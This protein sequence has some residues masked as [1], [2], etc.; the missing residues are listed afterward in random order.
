MAFKMKGSSLYGSP[1]KKDYGALSQE[2]RDRMKRHNDRGADGQEAPRIAS[3]KVTKVEPSKKS[4]K[5][6]K[7]DETFKPTKKATKKAKRKAVAAKIFGSGSKRKA[8]EQN[9]K[10]RQSRSVTGR[11]KAKASKFG[12]M[13]T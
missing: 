4:V 9:K 5:M 6:Q 7:A 2:Q 12:R 13:G 3:K 8:N 11:M 10:K 1:L